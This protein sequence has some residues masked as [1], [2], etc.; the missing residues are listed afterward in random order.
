[1]KWGCMR[2]T[3]ARDERRVVACSCS[4]RRDREEGYGGV[5]F[6]V[7]RSIALGLSQ[8]S[9]F[10]FFF[11]SFFFL[12]CLPGSSRVPKR[13]RKTFKTARRLDRLRFRSHARS[14]NR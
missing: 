9:L 2:L 6:Y 5:S 12:L 14:E 8:R 4:Y 13:K 11:L 1:M 3:E 7:Y 10:F